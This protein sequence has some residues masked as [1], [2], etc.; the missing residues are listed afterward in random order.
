MPQLEGERL[1]EFL[2]DAVD[3]MVTAVSAVDPAAVDPVV[4][5]AYDAAL[6]LVGQKLAGAAGRYPAIGEGWK[7]VLPACAKHL[8]QAPERTVAAISNALHSLA[9]SGARP[10]EWIDAMERLAPQCADV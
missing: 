1:L 5:V 4:S 2:R 9:G 6:T 3:P 7:R 10:S 8:A